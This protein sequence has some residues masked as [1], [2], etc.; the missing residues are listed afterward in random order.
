MTQIVLR[1]LWIGV[2]KLTLGDLS[3]KFSE[4]FG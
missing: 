1:I 4:T 3:S 2:R